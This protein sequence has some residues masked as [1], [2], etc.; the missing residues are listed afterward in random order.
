MRK[1]MPVLKIENMSAQETFLKNC[2]IAAKYRE[3]QLLRCKNCQYFS[4]KQCQGYC[5]RFK[6]DSLK[7]G[8]TSKKTSIL[9]ALKLNGLHPN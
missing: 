5:L 3:H 4:K 6:A 2:D 7:K 8:N 1:M 9:S